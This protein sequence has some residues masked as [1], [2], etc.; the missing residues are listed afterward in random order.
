MKRKLYLIGMF[1]G[2]IAVI[3]VVSMVMIFFEMDWLS[4]RVYPIAGM[5]MPEW[6]DNFK[7]WATAGI[8][9]ASV[10]S[11]LWYV[12]GLSVFRFNNWNKNYRVFW[13]L[14]FFAAIVPLAA[15]GW[16]FTKE[17]TAGAGWAYFFYVVNNFLIYYCA[18]ILFS[19]PSVMYTPLGATYLRWW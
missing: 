10:V 11:L 3:S 14:L 4:D 15:L 17:P 9:S 2:M 8:I 7:L 19:P 18:T 12:L 13:W 16:L 6:L 5:K 1:V